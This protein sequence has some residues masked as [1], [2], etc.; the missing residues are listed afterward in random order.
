MLIGHG[1]GRNI[2]GDSEAAMSE[3]KNCNR[4]VFINRG[5]ACAGGVMIMANAHAWPAL[6]GERAVGDVSR[7]GRIVFDRSTGKTWT[8][9]LHVKIETRAI[10][11]EFGP[12][13]LTDARDRILVGAPG[14]G[15]LGPET[16]VTGGQDQAKLDPRIDA[17]GGRVCVAWCAMDHDTRQWRV[18]AAVRD[19]GGQWG[20]PMEVAGGE[21]PALHPDVAVDPRSGRV[22]VAYEDW[23]DGSVRLTSW[24]GGAWSRPDKLSEGGMNFRPRVIVTDADGKHKGALAVAWDSYR[25]GQYDIFMRMAGA[26]GAMSVEHRVTTCARWDSEPAIAEDREGNIWL[27]WVRAMTDLTNYDR[28]RV[29]HA[30]FFD[31]ERWLWPKS[32]EGVPPGSGRLTGNVTNMHPEV[33]VDDSNRVHIFFRDTDSAL[34]GFLFVKSYLGDRWTERVKIKSSKIQDALNVIWDYSVT[35]DDKNRA[36]P[37]WDSLYVKRLG[38]A[39]DVHPCFP[40]SLGKKPDNP[41]STSGF[42]GPDSDAPGWPRRERPPG[43][44]MEFGGEKLTLLYG[45]THT[46]SWTSDGVDPADYYYHVARDLVGLDYYALSDHDF[47]VSNAPGLEAYISFLPK[48]WNSPDFVCFQAYEFSSQKTGHRVVVFEGDDNPTFPLTYPPKHK[49]NSNEELYPFLRKFAYSPESRVLVTAHNMYA[50]GNNFIGHDPELEPLYD[51][52][53]MHVLAEKHYSAYASEFQEKSI[54]ATLGPLMRVGSTPEEKRLWNMCWRDC[55]EDG[56]LLG[57][58]GTSDTHSANG[59]GYVVSALWC[60]AKTRKDIF[61]A[62]FEKRSFAIDSGIRSFHNI[63]VDPES[64][65]GRPPDNMLRAYVRL[66]ADGA[67][68]GGEA[69][70]GGTPAIRV[71]AGSGDPSDPVRSV[72]IV[73][74]SEEVHVERGGKDEI[75]FEWRD[76]GGRPQ[77]RYY[78]ARVEFEKGGVAFSSPVFIK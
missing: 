14:V 70:L 69:G 21:R 7:M 16:D 29:I 38:F 24:D 1:G 3:K 73:R 52:T 33:R 48:V 35:L 57:A 53:S 62:M 13:K 6:A 30:R 23:A 50:M 51:V 11:T 22:W 28:M 77:T 36:L 9:R 68:M 4:R 61:D 19:E 10:D 42:E 15:G 46:H 67:F 49:S 54:W 43:R 59:I 47:T 56:L 74:D 78:Y 26:E 20:A 31:G 76:E 25:G 32:P 75:S 17:A 44:T 71:E 60:R 55:L 65:L 66:W 64:G 34:F 72:A 27:V 39:S 58:Y 45:D 5:L 18:Y 41:Y 40:V 2:L 8:S 63:D 12:T 37:I